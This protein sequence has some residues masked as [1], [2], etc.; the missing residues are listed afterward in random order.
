MKMHSYMTVNGYLRYASTRSEELLT[1]LERVTLAV[2]SMEDAIESAKS[3]R[4]ELDYAE[5][6]AGGGTGTGSESEMGPSVSVTPGLS[7]GTTT[8]HY[9]DASTANALRKR[10]AAVAANPAL[11]TPSL[12]LPN[13][14][15]HVAG[16]ETPDV[17][18]EKQNSRSR[19]SAPA[20]PPAYA[21]VDHPDEGIAALAREYCEIDSELTSSGP[22]YVKFPDNITWKNFAVYHCIPTLVYELEY[23]RTDRWVS[24]RSES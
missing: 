14:N 16:L 1:E 10:L 22:N 20:K 2:G 4:A 9:T 8:S 24:F 5:A 6:A 11:G 13:P 7:T 21:L 18:Q 12:E 19:I 3:R 23:P 17:E 15:F